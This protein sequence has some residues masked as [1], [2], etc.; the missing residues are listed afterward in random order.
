MHATKNFPWEFSQKSLKC[1]H[2]LIYFWIDLNDLSIL[3]F[4]FKIYIPGKISNCLIGHTIYF[5]VK[6][7]FSFSMS[8]LQKCNGG[9]KYKNFIFT[10]K[11]IVWPIK[12]LEILPGIWNWNQ[13]FK[14]D[15][16]LRSMYKYIRKWTYFSDFCENFQ[17]K[18]FFKGQ[19]QFFT[20]NYTYLYKS[21]LLRIFLNPYLIKAHCEWHILSQKSYVDL[22]KGF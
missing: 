8:P 20:I 5:H 14:I 6:I 11:Y 2:F 18:F 19:Y 7:K 10:W 4:W 1:V 13:N 3:K 12:W 17:G 9:L 22:L 16:S 15:G 21:L